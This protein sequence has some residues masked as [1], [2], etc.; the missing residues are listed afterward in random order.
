MWANDIKNLVEGSSAKVAWIVLLTSGSILLF[1]VGW[2]ATLRIGAYHQNAVSAYGPQ[3]FIALWGSAG[4]LIVKYIH[5]LTTFLKSK[6]PTIQILKATYGVEGGPSIDVKDK[7]NLLLKGSPDKNRFQFKVDDPV[8]LEISK[9]ND[10]MPGSAK[11]LLS[12]IGTS[13]TKDS[14]R[15][16]TLLLKTERMKCAHTQRKGRQSH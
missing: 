3:L 2:F 12:N 1:P 5:E 7:V 10:P 9:A 11:C 16:K 13:T 4:L 14:D 15:G 6:H 8:F